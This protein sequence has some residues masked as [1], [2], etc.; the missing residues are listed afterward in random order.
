ML[1]FILQANGASSL[2]MMLVMFVIFY[3]FFIRPNMNKQ[4]EQVT[5]Q[6]E[7]KKGDEVVTASGIIGKI[8]RIDD[9]EVTLDIDGKT[10]MRFTIGAISKEMTEAFRK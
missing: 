1:L 6:T 2:I 8:N 5:F 4:K 10:F 9:K 3:F 7:L